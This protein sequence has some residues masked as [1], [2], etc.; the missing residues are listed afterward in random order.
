MS[1]LEVRTDLVNV[2]FYWTVLVT[3]SSLHGFVGWFFDRQYCSS[4][5][6]MS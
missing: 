6:L 1:G 2:F 4:L 5:Y 3:A